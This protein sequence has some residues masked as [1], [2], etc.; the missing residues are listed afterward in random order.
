MVVG[1]I[2]ESVDLLVV[3]GGPGGYT[4]ALDAAARGRSV[5]LVDADGERGI[6]GVCLRVG[7]IPS[8]A[9]IEVAE[10]YHRTA[11]MEVAGLPAASGEVDMKAFQRWKA[12]VVDRLAG[13]VAGLLSKAG[14]RIVEGRFRFLGP[15]RGMVDAGGARPPVFLE[16]ADVVLA[17]GSTPV[18][19]PVLP[20]DGVHVL[21]STDALALDRVPETV[22]V[23]GGGYIGVELGT[24]LAKL[25]SSVTVVE[26]TDSLLPGLPDDVVRPVQRRLTELGV[27]VLLGTRVTGQAAGGPGVRVSGADGAER[28]VPAEVAVVA[29]GRTPNTADLGLDSIGVTPGPGG[30]LAV[31]PDRLVAPH[32]AAIGDITDGPAL[33]HKATAEATVAVEALCG[34]AAAFDPATIPLVVFSDPEIA[35]AGEAGRPGEG[36]VSRRRPFSASGRA[37]TMDRDSGFLRITVDQATQAVVGVEVVGPHASEL[38]SEGVLA[39]EMAASPEDLWGSIHP[40][41]T[42]A[43]SLADVA[44]EFPLP[45]RR[46]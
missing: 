5:T 1:Q 33:A 22:L 6:G 30:R 35:V 29:V 4:A 42:L 34:D 9:L 21:D 36:R 2:A 25:G 40:H 10:L 16:F 41:P 37:V 45:G 38:I 15:G 14:V 43:E 12:S 3:G 17:T 18:D 26:A 13:G 27:T 46:T 39:I 11:T 44:R 28:T 7:C 20:R 31:G 23:V 24:A 8:K 19:L 32:V